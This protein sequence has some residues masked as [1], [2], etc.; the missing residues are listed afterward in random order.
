MH[1]DFG[2]PETIDNVYGYLW[3]A[4]LVVTATA[5]YTSV[6]NLGVLL[7]CKTQ[8]DVIRLLSRAFA[9]DCSACQVGS[10]EVTGWGTRP[11]VAE[12][13]KLIFAYLPSVLTVVGAMLFVACI[14][15]TIFS[16]YGSRVG[17]LALGLALVLMGS[18]TVRAIAIFFWQSWWR[19]ALVS[20]QQPRRGVHDH[21]A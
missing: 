5:M 14:L 19:A 6:L 13:E 12:K 2:A 10:E 3:T 4:C 17:W 8:C 20:Y 7:C 16:K 18:C 1:E 21:A 11:G 9:C 15:W